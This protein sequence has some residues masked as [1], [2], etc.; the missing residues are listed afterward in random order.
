[1]SKLKQNIFYNVFYQLFSILTPLI[2][3]PYLVRVFTREQI[4]LNS[5]SLS[6]VTVFIYISFMGINSYGV[7]EISYVKQKKDISKYFWSLWFIQLVGVLITLSIFDIIILNLVSTNKTVIFIQSFLILINIFDISWFFIGMEELK[8]TV[9]RNTFI[10]ICS[11]FSI[12]IFI[13]DSSD[14][15]KY[16]LIN[17]ISTL[18]ANIMLFIS[19]KKYISFPNISK[20]FVLY[21]LKRSWIFLLP[22]ISTFMYTTF[23]KVILGNLS[24]MDQVAYYEQANGIVRLST[25]LISCVGTALLPR[26][27]QLLSENKE[28]EIEVTYSQIFKGVSLASFYMFT[29]LLC[30]APSFVDWFFSSEYDIVSTIIRIEAIIIIIA[31]ISNIVLNAILLPRRHDKIAI[32]STLY[33]AITNIVLNTLLDR[34][35]G[36]YG[37]VVSI[38]ITEIF[39]L[40]YRI[41]K[42]RNYYSYVIFIKSTYKYL[43]VSIFVILTVSLINKFIHHSFLETVSTVFLVT[44]I[45][46]ALLVLI[47]DDFIIKHLKK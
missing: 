33:A 35:L 27:T 34:R 11:L 26:I 9:T 2:T 38:I 21:H 44:I 20:D 41:Y 8:K 23:D 36:V 22:Q 4:G 17:I 10:K 29:M 1:M 18:L 39:C 46:I 30:V 12:F 40:I 25:N 19:L 31:P 5:Y 28:K 45:F 32:K 43:F 42:S 3:M 7:R 24:N 16:L 13:K 6:L 37:C 14:F 47:K 15:H